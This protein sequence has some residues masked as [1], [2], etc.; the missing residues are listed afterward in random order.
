MNAIIARILVF[1]EN[2]QKREV[3]LGPGLNIVTG[4]SKTGK[5]ALLEI[6]DYCLFSGRSTV[7][8]GVIENF[9]ELYAIVLD[10]SGKYLVIARSS[11]RT[12]NGARAYVQVETNNDFLTDISDEY[13][14]F[15]QDKPLK[16]AQL[17]VEQ[18]LGLSVLDTRTDEDERKQ[19]S[20]GKATLRSFASFIF[21][22]QN[23]IA[24]KHSVFYRFEDFYKRKKT[25]Q[26][27]PILMGWESSEYF[28]YLRELEQKKNDL[29]AHQKLAKNLKL[30]KDELRDQ[31]RSVIEGYYDVIGLEVPSNLSLA[32]IKKIARNLPEVSPCSYSDAN[33][34]LRIEER[35]R[36]REEFRKELT[37]VEVLLSILE[38]NSAVTHGH[39]S[40]L[41][42]LEMTSRVDVDGGPF[43]CPV[44]HQVN[45]ELSEELE[46]ISVSREELEQEL[47]KIGTYK[48]DNSQQVEELQR[49]RDNFKRQIRQV[50]SEIGKFEVQDVELQENKSLRDQGFRAKGSAEARIESLLSRDGHI[51]SGDADELN[52]RIG[53]L[54]EKLDGFDLASKISA[55][56]VFLSERMTSICNRLD[57]EE[58]LKPGELKFLLEDFAFYYHFNNEKVHLSEM[59][60]GA[61][62][63]ACHL[64]L[65]LGLLH[66]NCQAENSVIPSFLFIDQPSQVYFPTKYRTVEEDGD[67]DLDENIKQVVNIFSVI[68]E[69]LDL[70]EEDCG[71]LPQVVVME[72]ADEIEFNKYVKKRWYKNGEKLI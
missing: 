49:Q 6:V 28:L 34:K 64:S 58:E 23:L 37:D 70:I 42:F 24:N 20:G 52:E 62:W 14:E 30:K 2:H 4:D 56:E 8:K 39:A 63:L 71:F 66:L 10:L 51:L 19:E 54:K 57:F 55:A 53:W 68:I 31:L 72:H 26:D 15:I 25:I 48:E 47:E 35:E 36:E 16:Q 65:F 29:K 50:T 46:I 22:H 13:F 61:N 17:E 43:I 9:A 59:G 67:V 21:Q 7:P 45:S 40:Q 1:G 5:S 27:F 60:S 12:G 32:E 44:C 38:D 11:A 3:E 18:H 69:E 33:L 41:R